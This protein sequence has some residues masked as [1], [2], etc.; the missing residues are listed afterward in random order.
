MSATEPHAKRPMK[1]SSQPTFRELDRTECDAILGRNQV[2]R[3]AFSFHDRVDIEPIHYVHRGDWIYVRTAP[4]TKIMTVAHN[5]WVAFEV[6]EID[7][8]FDWRSVVVRG[9]VYVID[10]DGTKDDKRAHAEAV[11][12]LQ[13]IVPETFSSRDPVAFRYV[14]LRIH[15][16][17]ITGRSATTSMS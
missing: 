9:S 13:T 17:D 7:G 1:P 12:L 4:G 5:R 3:I 14:I 8:I 10:P 16:D 11:E 15:V 6:D 2:G